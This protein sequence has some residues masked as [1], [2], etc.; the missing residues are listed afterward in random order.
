MGA[1]YVCDETHDEIMETIFSREELHYDKLILEGE[2]ESS[3]HDS[4]YNEKQFF[5]MI[6]LSMLYN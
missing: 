2:S 4:E 5:H 6:L 1:V 3:D